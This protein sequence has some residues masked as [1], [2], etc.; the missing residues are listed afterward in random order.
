MGG[1]AVAEW[2]AE[3]PARGIAAA[4][5]KT[6]SAA[7]ASA[8]LAAAGTKMIAVTLGPAWIGLWGTLTQTRQTALVAA[9][10]N[11]QTALVQGINALDRRERAEFFRTALVL[12]GAATLA[13]AAVMIFARESVA[14]AA[15]LSSGS[16]ALIAWLSIGVIFGSAAVVL[17]ALLN[18]FGEIGKL[19]WLQLA[20]PAAIAVMAAGGVNL[21]AMLVIGAGVSAGSA[22]FLLRGFWGILGSW[23]QA[24]GSWFSFAAARRFFSISGAMALTGFIAN[25]GL[26]AVRARIIRKAG[27]ATAG[28]FDAAWSISMNQVTLV[29]ASMQTY[30]MPELS[31]ARSDRERREHVTGVMRM[32]I[33]ASA[34]II[35]A[36]AMLKPVVILVLYSGK[37][38]GAADF[39]RW[40]LVG[41]YLKVT[42]WVLAIPM[43]ASADMRT[44]LAV[45]T[46]AQ[47]VFLGS[48][49]AL[50]AS[51]GPAEG[52][53]MGF[54]A[55]YA[56]NLVVCYGYARRKLH[57]RFGKIG[58]LWAAGM[59]LVC[60]VNFR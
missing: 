14:S 28:N 47:V 31:R 36:I 22:I 35:A 48:S 13:I 6:G 12:I 9:T 49:W 33:L 34:P 27:L 20:G 11:G 43:I 39:L 19:A 8:L 56:V 18:A 25:A 57:W 2:K 42:S 29:L 38:A 15:G 21:V 37:F 1:G 46:L 10:A 44:F 41:D 17:T 59:M 30:Y 5:G 60:A 23:I 26:V 4:M 55:C 3:Q 24:P 45:D 51:R 7:L 54:A 16:G 58:W 52:A 32:A 40:T 50:A 53:A